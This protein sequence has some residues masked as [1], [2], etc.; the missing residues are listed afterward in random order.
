TYGLCER[1]QKPIPEAR[2]EAVPAS[3]FCIE[4]A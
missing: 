4:H 3:R 2:L 1:C